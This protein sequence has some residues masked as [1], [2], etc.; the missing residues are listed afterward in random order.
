MAQRFIAG[1]DEQS[2]S[3]L[4]PSGTIEDGAFNR[5]CRDFLRCMMAL[6]PSSELLSYYHVSLRGFAV[7]LRGHNNKCADFSRTLR[8]RN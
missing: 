4:V 3:S 1:Y 5:P 8:W 2:P 7:L 6:F